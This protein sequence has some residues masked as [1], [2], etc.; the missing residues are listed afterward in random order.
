MLSAV[1]IRAWN[2][3]YTGEFSNDHSVR[4]SSGLIMES[5]AK[6]LHKDFKQGGTTFTLAE[7]PMA[8]WAIDNYEE[9][10]WSMELLT[11]MAA[12][13]LMEHNAHRTRLLCG[14]FPELKIKYV[15]RDGS[16]HF[17]W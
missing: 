11:Y 15:R 2:N 8:Q 16:I 4:L 9:L 14:R 12:R 6:K 1:E 13:L 17:T 5:I 10:G 3:I 7:I